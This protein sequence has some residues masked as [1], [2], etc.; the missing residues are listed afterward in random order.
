M[1]Y[2]RLFCRAS[3]AAKPELITAEVHLSSGIPKFNIVGL[4]ETSI[5][6]SK[7]RVRSAILSSHMEF[8]RKIITVNLAPANMPK[9]GS[10]FDLAIAIGI[11]IASQQLK[12][13]NIDSY[14]FA[15][16]LGLLGEIKSSTNI[17]NI[18]YGCSQTTRTLVTSRSDANKISSVLTLKC[19]AADNLLAI[20]EHLANLKPI[21]TISGNNNKFSK[22]I[23]Y[24]SN[25]NNIIG[26][27]HAKRALYIAAAGGHS[28]LLSGPPGVGKSMLAK[29]LPHMMPPMS[30]KEAIETAIVQD[31]DHQTS[32][33]IGVRPFRSPHHTVS[34]AGLIGG[35]N[36]PQPGEISFANNGVLFLDEL[37]EFSRNTLNCLRQ[38]LEDGK[39]EITRSQY[40]ASFPAKFQLIAT[41]NPCP[42]GYFGST[43]KNC[44][45]S[46][47]EIRTY[48]NKI[49]G[50]LLDRIDLFCAMDNIKI[51]S[52]IN[53]PKIN[54]LDIKTISAAI[55]AAHKLQIKIQN[56]T[57][58][59]ASHETI[60]QRSKFSL[61]TT[62]FLEQ[63][64][65]KL[66]ISARSYCK[67]IRLARTIADLEQSSDIK[68]SH[69]TE[70]VSYRV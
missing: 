42:C 57:N 16:E 6:E 33:S 12:A 25:I 67:I 59:Q 65:S 20:F 61:Q 58:A 24:A 27:E 64:T 56:S 60:I 43:N 31:Y 30:K 52:L 5:K 10:Q 18:A 69:I 37:A 11:L 35:G 19:I 13:H 45:C 48:Q 40:K 29:C 66:N 21:P 50:P 54:E 47:K 22:P 8:P 49:A 9:K 3:F 55:L 26:Q 36:P 62:K 17:L 38:P 70:A 28:L 63:I 53:K 1:S 14:E 15:G 7:D 44:T 68:K 41:T 34:S 51:T 32:Y 23:S 46:A 39:I 4:G 2:A